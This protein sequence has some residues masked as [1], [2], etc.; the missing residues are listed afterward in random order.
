V[1]VPAVTGEPEPTWRLTVT[2]VPTVPVGAITMIVVPVDLTL[3]VV[4]CSVP[5]STPVTAP[6]PLPVMVTLVPPGPEV[7][8][9]AL[10]VGPRGLLVVVV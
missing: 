4:P 5:K 1:N 3:I 2:D 6:N 9:S 7:G 10:T 8:V